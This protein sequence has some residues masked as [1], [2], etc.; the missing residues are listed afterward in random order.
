MCAAY[1]MPLTTVAAEEP[2]EAQ[3]V[4]ETVAPDAKAWSPTATSPNAFK[5]T[6]VSPSSI[7]VYYGQEI[8][9]K[10]EKNIEC[11]FAGSESGSA[12]SNANAN[13]TFSIPN[14]KDSKF[15]SLSGTK[16][17]GLALTKNP[18]TVCVTAK[19]NDGKY[20]AE[21][22]LS[23]NVKAMDLSKLD[24]IDCFPVVQYKKSADN[25]KYK[26]LDEFIKKYKGA[27]GLTVKIIKN[28][29][30]TETAEVATLSKKDISKVE[31][32]AVSGSSKP[33]GC[34][35]YTMSGTA[36]DDAI[37]S[38]E[39]SVEGKKNYTGK[40][41]Y[42]WTFDGDDSTGVGPYGTLGSANV[43]LEPQ[44]ISAGTISGQSVTYGSIASVIDGAEYEDGAT[45]A[46]ITA[47]NVKNFK[48]STKSKNIKVNAKGEVTVKKIGATDAENEVEVTISNKKNK[49]AEGKVKFNIIPMTISGASNVDVSKALKK[50][51]KSLA[52]FEKKFVGAD[53][54]KAKASGLVFKQ[55]VNS[56]DVNL[57]AG[58][59][60]FNVTVTGMG[61]KGDGD[62]YFTD[63]NKT[64]ISTGCQLI[65]EGKGNYAGTITC[66][67]MTVKLEIQ[68]VA[69]TG[70][71]T[72]GPSVTFGDT[73]TN[74]LD[75]I[76]VDKSNKSLKEDTTNQANILKGLKIAADKSLKIAKDGKITVKSVPDSHK[77]KIVVTA[78]KNK[79]S[80]DAVAEAEIT[81]N[82][83]DAATKADKF[84]LD[85]SKF[86]SK[87]FKSK[88]AAEAAIKKVVVTYDGKKLK[89][90]KD[91][92][93]PTVSI[94]D[95]T[96]GQAIQVPVSVT[97]KGNY[98]GTV[99]D[100]VSITKSAN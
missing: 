75:W 8:D 97:L 76:Y 28:V 93:E 35:Y 34:E 69:V 52:D 60:D 59:K 18:V 1:A 57:K 68:T 46:A 61:I 86:S 5:I 36:D 31:V 20:S 7:D 99:S 42:D 96:T 84:K 27:K 95:N 25:K 78:K 14:S 15:L 91:Y 50:T 51:Y 98:T 17:K 87:T 89:V 92:N 21:G 19:T 32:R 88:S 82:P 73:E 13:L 80:K 67:P 70:G 44:K 23:I 72:S 41:G 39:I 85:A 6:K 48:F 4:V 62:A 47:E 37:A 3:A 12:I 49:K 9:L 43:N 64:A 56:K 16:V 65:I 29:S 94:T 2:A 24:D 54:T 81:V 90:N 63:S 55:K 79:A 83:L 10:T 71:G 45:T 66:D 22:Q 77:A 33:T 40:T 30:Q 100:N 74:V 38:V 11:E 53:K 26:N 58:G